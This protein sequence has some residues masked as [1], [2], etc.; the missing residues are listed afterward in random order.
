MRSGSNSPDPE[1]TEYLAQFGYVSDIPGALRTK[2]EVKEALLKFQAIA[3]VPQS[4]RLD[5]QTRDAMQRPRCGLPDTPALKDPQ[6]FELGPSSWMKKSLT[7]S[8]TGSRLTSDLNRDVIQR[9]IQRAVSTWQSV[10]SLTFREVDTPKADIILSFDRYDHGDGF[11][12]DGRGRV[13]AH[14]F[15]P[16]EDRGG[17]VHFDDD[18]TWTSESQD[19]TNLFTV[20]AHEVGHSLGIAHSQVRGALM[21]PWYQ[22]Y[23]SNLQLHQD[24]IDAI[25]RLYGG[26]TDPVS[27]P[28]STPRPQVTDRG[29]VTARA[30]P[31]NAPAV[32]SCK[33]LDSV[34]I[35]RG[36]LFVFKDKWYWRMNSRGWITDYPVK[37]ND[38]WKG[39]PPSKDKIDA[40][41]ERADTGKIIFFKGNR[42]FEFDANH[43]ANGFPESGRSI[44][45]FGL[46][47]RL[48]RLD[49]VFI[50]GY[51]KNIYAFS[52]D[53]FWLLKPSSSRGSL[54]VERGFPKSSRDF[55]RGV[56][57]P[58]DAVVTQR[59]DK[60]YF[61]KGNQYWLF[62]DRTNS[63]AAGYPRPSNE[64]WQHCALAQQRHSPD[65]DDTDN[66]AAKF[67][68]P[69]NQC[70]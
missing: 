33:N 38:F 59:N 25:Q 2:D 66:F 69:V 20:A 17:D 39:F 6:N 51:D 63:T 40:A 52:G 27:A 67:S 32:D 23:T 7:Y 15:P 50:W 47:S 48:D 49:D 54:Q 61:F 16:G 3:N 9:E 43:M 42:Y 60:T 36:E 8:I 13:L 1:G 62:D 70:F 65:P 29:G 19:G 5:D 34:S 14:A 30:P 37:I 21:F 4:G 44:T 55:W 58:I 56:Q 22:G 26:R 28:D 10:S 46:P 18:E 68:A 24:D 64:L 12:F 57:F 45:D 11:S 53:L 41:F 31:T 35:I